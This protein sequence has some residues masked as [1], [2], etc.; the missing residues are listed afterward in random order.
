VRA[1]EL[2]EKIGSMYLKAKQYDDAIAAYRKAQA[3]SPDGA[4]RLHFNLAL[5][6]EK[7]GS[8]S[9]ALDSVESYLRLLP[10]GLDAYELKIKLMK[11]LGKD[12]DILSW[13]EQASRNDR[14]NV[15]L[16]LLLGRSY[17]HSGKASE[18]E[19]VYV[20][21][22]SKSP[23]AEVYR[24]LFRLYVDER[25]LGPGRALTLLNTTLEEAK[26]PPPPG[27]NPAPAQADAMIMALRDDA[28]LARDLVKFAHER[29][30]AGLSAQTLLLLAALADRQ[31]QL[32]ESEKFYRACLKNPPENAEGAI[33]SGLLRVLWKARKYDDIVK[34]CRQVLVKFPAAASFHADMARALAIQG[35]FDQALVE[36][37]R[38][39]SQA[40]GPDRF[41]LR[42][43]KV[44][45]LTIAERFDKA[46]A[47]CQGMLKDA[48][49]PGEML[50]IHYILSNVHS[51]AHRLSRAEEELKLVLKMDPDNATANNDLGYIWADQDKN[52]K[53][54]EEM[55]R[56][57]IELDR[58]ARKQPAA[59]ESD[60]DN[61]AY[62]DSLGWVL[63]RRGR[64]ESARHE[65]E[66]AVTLPDGDD[67]TIY[68]HLGDVY[69]QLR[70]FD[71]VRVAWQQALTLY[72]RDRLRTMDQKYKDLKR[73]Y[74][75]LDSARQP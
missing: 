25:R 17:A 2:Y 49:Q 59:A 38:G 26:L 56:K 65:L 60:E 4:G 1:A 32:P 46:E 3:R 66:R 55:I 53:Q 64:L 69:Y 48:L 61:A 16:K 67:P 23:S 18:A 5:V 75:L 7:Q 37:E 11:A 44:R 50:D 54:A 63:F 31:R 30:Q 24:G 58:R 72:E 52:L 35:H 45:V 20:E 12:A 27:P 43:A 36:I 62:V 19:K 68:D 42:Y 9:R 71:R 15:G 39:L 22:A 8:L 41:R 28:R 57:A 10:Q 70:Q 40:A 47:E 33:C 29:W 6:F 74:K 21:L 34:L 13:L 51:S 73:K 14:F